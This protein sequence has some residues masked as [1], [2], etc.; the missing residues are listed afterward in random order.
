MSNE[1]NTTKLSGGPFPR[2][3]GKGIIGGQIVAHLARR[4]CYVEPFFGA[5]GLF[6]K[7]PQGTYELEMVNDLEAAVVTFFR[8]LRDR[9]E[10]LIRQ[11]ELTPYAF[12]EYIIACQ[13]SDS[14]LE[15]ARRV[16]VRCRQGISGVT[17]NRRGNWAWFGVNCQTNRLDSTETKLGELH[18]YAARLRTVQIDNR[19]A[20]ELINLKVG[21]AHAIYSD[22]P[23]L[24]ETRNADNGYLLEMTEAD[25]QRL[26]E[27]HHSAV[28]RGAAVAVSGYPSPLYTELYK[29]WR[30]VLFET[31][32]TA[33]VRTEQS[34]LRT[35]VL[36]MSYPPEEEFGANFRPTPKARSRQEQA[37]LSS[38]RRQLKVG[39]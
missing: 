6:F 35:E 21:A 28:K 5:G 1:G 32:S 36:W 3:G 13:D 22:P 17:R 39:R 18:R 34:R 14:D 11:C 25:H 7:I 20:I 8:V 30:S 24:H 10:E 4:K 2:Y 26:A 37:L 15:M 19:D 27:A 38:A 23:Y 16:W 29:G 33:G 9:P 12:D 31:G